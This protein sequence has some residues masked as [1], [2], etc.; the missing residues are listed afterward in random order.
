[1]TKMGCELGEVF[2]GTQLCQHRKT[3][4][5]LYVGPAHSITQHKTE[6]M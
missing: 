5:V 6:L 1:M 4:D 2:S 3:Y